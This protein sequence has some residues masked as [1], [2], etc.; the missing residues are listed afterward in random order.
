VG[1]KGSHFRLTKHS[2]L[3]SSAGNK[4]FSTQTTN[5]NWKET[6]A[7]FLESVPKTPTFSTFKNKI[8]LFILI[9]LIYYLSNHRF[10]VSQTMATNG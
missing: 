5:S 2:S 1:N 6:F 7:T 10:V 9:S 8:S 4:L 3:N